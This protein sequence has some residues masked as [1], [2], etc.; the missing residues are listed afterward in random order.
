MNA[1]VQNR[2]DVDHR[3]DIQINNNQLCHGNSQQQRVDTNPKVAET[4]VGFKSGFQ[5]QQNKKH[6]QCGFTVNR[7]VYD[8]A[9]KYYDHIIHFHFR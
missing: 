3:N 8:I 6:Y 4:T 9:L 5:S 1:L 2:M 7:L